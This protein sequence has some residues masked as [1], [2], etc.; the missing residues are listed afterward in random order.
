MRSCLFLL[1]ALTLA[2]VPG[3][4]PAADAPPKP[5][6]VVHEWGVI[7]VYNDVELANADMRAEW[8][9]LPKFVNGQIDDRKVPEYLREAKVPVIYFHA[10]QAM[11]L[12]VKIDFPNGKPTVWWPS[13]LNHGGGGLGKIRVEEP[14]LKSLTWNVQLRPAQ[15]AQVQLMPLPK[16]HWMEALRDVR[17][18]DVIA[19]VGGVQ[20]EKFIY[21]DG[22]IPSPKAAL[23]A[24]TGENV[25]IK[26]QAKYPLHD[27]TVVDLRNVRK[28]RVARVEKLDA[29][30][31]AKDVKF[32]EGDQAKWPT[33]AVATLVK[34]LQ[35]SGLFEDEAKAL[36]N[37]WQKTFFETEGVSVFY[38]LPQEVYDQ[39]LPLTLCVK[40]EKVVR[41]MLAH[42]PH[43]EPDLAD[44]VMA[45][46]KQLDA[47]KFEDRI[48]AQKRLQKLGR[49]AFVHLRRA[50]DSKPPLEVR[51]RLEKLLEEFEAEAGLRK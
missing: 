45:L 1:A 21:Y 5:G 35:A 41:T 3:V 2:F 31:E 39:L 43:V 47:P 20:K 17:A 44:R 16:G 38:R 26:N 33:D 40:P 12:N 13:T 28:I 29:G 48:E 25:G 15:A 51:M 36:A 27:L 49:A 34:Q 19:Y 22:L 24:V 42:H 10:A 7:S 14:A 9:G 23:I 4:V 37:V 6:L 11:A 46:V 30:S 18:D 50:R 8:A 32:T